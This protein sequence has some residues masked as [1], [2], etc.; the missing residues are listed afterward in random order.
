[1][2]HTNLFPPFVV[3]DRI[4]TFSYY[5]HGRAPGGESTGVLVS[6]EGGRYKMKYRDD[7]TGQVCGVEQEVFVT[8]PA[9]R[10]TF[11][12]TSRM[13]EVEDAVKT[14]LEVEA[15]LDQWEKL[16]EHAR[17]ILEALQQD[18][19]SN[20]PKG[21]VCR[22][23][24]SLRMG[25]ERYPTCGLCRANLFDDGWLGGVV[26]TASL[27]LSQQPYRNI[28]VLCFRLIPGVWWFDSTR[29]DRALAT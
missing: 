18:F 4:R 15:A 13:G 8:V 28:V 29:Y 9:T 14:F 27:P 22:H 24:L 3:G 12:P 21:F 19:D 23:P 5:N 7:Q 1:M 16:H 11:D 20:Q 26:V 25:S 10:P 2:S 6:V 17:A